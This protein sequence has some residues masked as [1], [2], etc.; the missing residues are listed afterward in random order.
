MTVKHED[1]RVERTRSALRAALIALII[2]KGYEAIT[3]QDII[4][5]ANVGRSTFYAHFLDKQQ[6]FLSSLA[7]LRAMLARHQQAAM[8]GRGGLMRG[9]F[10]FS[11]AMFEHAES[12]S[13][14]YQ[15]MVGKQSGMIVQRELQQILA[16]LARNELLAALPP[17]KAASLPLE[18]IVAHVVSAFM[19]LLTWWLDNGLPC[20]PVE[21]D[22]IFQLLTIPGVKAVLARAGVDTTAT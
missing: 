2:E 1:R 22:R 20:S 14:L 6:L 4:D 10:G 5:R 8:Q 16:D 18:A 15:A 13:Q 17:G 3:I 21:V 9:T 11:F 12:H 19:G 7:D